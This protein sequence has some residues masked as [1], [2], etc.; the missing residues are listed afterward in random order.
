MGSIHRRGR[1]TRDETLSAAANSFYEHGYA[2]T[3]PG[4]V[5]RQPAVTDKAIYH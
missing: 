5:A 3:T 1:L 2:Q 4:H